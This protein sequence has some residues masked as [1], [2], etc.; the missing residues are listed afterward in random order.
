M[1]NLTNL[2]GFSCSFCKSVFDF[3]ALKRSRQSENFKLGTYLILTFFK[4]LKLNLL[5]DS[6]HLRGKKILSVINIPT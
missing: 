6:N 5:K 1:S 4:V 2:S 3:K